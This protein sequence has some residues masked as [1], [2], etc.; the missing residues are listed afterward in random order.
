MVHIH[1]R[2]DWEEKRG[3]GRGNKDGKVLEGNGTKE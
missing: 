2:S 1:R 3:G